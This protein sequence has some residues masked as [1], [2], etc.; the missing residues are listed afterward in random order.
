[1]ADRE[2]LE[3]GLYRTVKTVSRPSDKFLFKAEYLEVE[4]L[5]QIET[6]VTEM[7]LNVEDVNRA[8]RMVKQEVYQ[9]ALS[10]SQDEKITKAI[11][12][13][14]GIGYSADDAK[15]LA[16]AQRG[17]T[18]DLPKGLSPALD[19]DGNQRI[20]T[21]GRKAAEKPAATEEKAA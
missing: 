18:S 1:M 16:E 2:K 13:L 20:S 12:A 7:G 19:K 21:K 3:N 5:G 4:N 10:T 6:A 11:A 15:G 17:K 8:L 9:T 14:V